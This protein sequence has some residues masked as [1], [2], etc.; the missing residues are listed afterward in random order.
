ME[1][2]INA[3]IK[4]AIA[5]DIG[6]GDHSSLA[7]IPEDA[8]GKVQLLVKE[9]GV[10]A[11][12]EIARK[13]IAAIDSELVLKVNIPDGTQ[14]KKGDIALTIKGRTRSI[15]QAERLILNFMQ[16]MSGIATQ[17][18]VY[19]DKISDLKTKVLDTRKTTPGLR[20]IEKMAVA[21]GG[22]QN[23]RMGL[24][25]MIMLKDNHIDFAGGIKPAIEQTQ[26]YLR[27][28]GK[29]LRIEIEVR[30]LD[31]LNE[32]LE[33]GGIHR[34]MLDNFS[35]EDTRRAVERINGR[36]EIESSGG[37]T[38][39]TLRDYA[40]CGVDF[41]SVGALTHQIKSLDLSLKAV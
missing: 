39:E 25:D 11:G 34:I 8:K 40:E 9:A 22:G 28:L 30:N 41:I 14:I 2:Q 6:D 31:E 26:A 4:Q 13:V 24:Y 12:T 1:E 5:E 38:L 23:H 19:A 33:T 29:S 16:R 20:A 21:I 7:C 3:L 18:A 35:T 32:V 10:L 15:L 27:N 17:T 36:Y 37:I